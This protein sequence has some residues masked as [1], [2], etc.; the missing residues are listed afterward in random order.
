[1]K[2]S[3]RIAIAQTFR[4]TLIWEGYPAHRIVL[5]GSVASDEATADSD[6]DIAVICEPFA[7]TRH[8]EN[9]VLRRLRWDI[10]IRI[11][12]ICLHPDDFTNSGFP[13]AGE[14]RRTGVVV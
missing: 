5:F 6:L 13:L 4:G 3:E 7:A 14:V 1:M 10:D 11:K 8:E 2:P 9:M 12:P